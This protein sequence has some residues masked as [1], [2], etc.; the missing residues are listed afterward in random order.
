MCGLCGIVDLS[1]P[2]G[3]FEQLTGMTRMVRHRGPDDEGFALFAPTRFWVAEGG[4]PSEGGW[5]AGLGHRRLSIIDLSAGG[6]QPMR[7]VTGRFWIVL[8]GEIY[9]FVE[10]RE[11]LIREGAQFRSRSDT[12]VALE[13]FIRWGKAC[14][15]RFNG[16]WA[17]AV[18]DRQREELFLAR[19]RFG[20]KP[21]YYASSA[22]SFAFASEIKQLHSIA[23]GARRVNREVLAD[24]LF[25]KYEGHTNETFFEGI[26]VFPAGHSVSLSRDD[27][28]TGRVQPERYWVYEPEGSLGPAVAAERF[29]E[30]LTDAV[31]LRLRSDVPVAVTLSGGL[32]SS[33]VTCLAAQA[34]GGTP[35]SALT[36]F[37][38]VFP[39]KAFSEQPFAQ[40]VTDLCGARP[41]YI[42][43][44]GAELVDDWGRFVWN[45]EEPFSS[46]SY[47]AN[48]KVYEKVAEHHVPVVLNGQG[49]DE[50]LMGYDRY[51]VP[52]LVQAW[53]R[54]RYRHLAK[55]SLAAGTHA[56]LSLPRQIGYLVYFGL[57][58]VRA[59]R[60]RRLVRPFLQRDFF[61]FGRGRTEHLVQEAVSTD[62]VA[63]QGQEFSQ[64]QLPH[65]L[66]HEDRVSMNFSIESRSPFLDYR[67]LNFILGQDVGLLVQ[68]G[69]SKAILRES[70]KGI[71]PEGVRT[72]RIKMG[73]DTPTGR[74]IR[75]GAPFFT[76]LLKRNHDDRVLDVPAL[77]RA[78][79]R[80][81]ID[82]LLLCGACSYLSWKETFQVSD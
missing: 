16:M 18:Y 33:S 79:D 70:M 49:G 41:V 52:L 44:G 48:W 75:E 40:Q 50:L 72:R 68:D 1:A 54:H 38:A 42:E 31:R 12:E 15:R 73:F 17:L 19:D 77:N 66:H 28:A 6:H 62:R 57:P 37:T 25:W 81:R 80:G 65:L 29:R 14:L 2:D 30:L 7:D 3:L 10:L 45:M 22:G 51:R 71:L 64:Y 9:N 32:D 11:E 67:L 74:L 59:I 61:E 4:T 46:L 21:L 56:G 27:V 23:G 47:Y 76:E 20:V 5:T 13:A 82:E 34:L 24:F 58:K 60:R 53:R 39:D 26:N 55:E 8:N 69:Y 36:A 78:F 43:P 35:A 63:W